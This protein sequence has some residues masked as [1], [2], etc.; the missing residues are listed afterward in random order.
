LG[1]N[2]IFQNGESNF[3]G[4]GVIMCFYDAASMLS[5]VIQAG[6]EELE[7]TAGKSKS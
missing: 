1:I 5:R 6:F 4:D 7:L 2:G 3:Y